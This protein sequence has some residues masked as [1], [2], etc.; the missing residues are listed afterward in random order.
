M[1]PAALASA[2]R[3]QPD[4]TKPTASLTACPTNHNVQLLVACVVSLQAA[5]SAARGVIALWARMVPVFAPLRRDASQK[6]VHA[7]DMGSA[8]AGCSVL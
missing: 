1:T 6:A 8:A 7:V 3:S 4:P 2:A 5:T